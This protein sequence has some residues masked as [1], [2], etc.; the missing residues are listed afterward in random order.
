MEEPLRPRVGLDERN[1]ALPPGGEPQVPKRLVV[2]REEVARC[3]A[4]GRHV[5]N[6]GAVGHGERCE[7]MPEELDELADHS[8]TTEDLR[9]RQDEVGGRSALR[10]R[11]GQPKTDDLGDEHRDR[12]TQHRC[13]GFDPADTP[14]EHSKPVHHRRMRVGADERVGKCLTVA[15]LDDAGEV[16]EVDLMAD[17]GVRRHDTEVVERVLAPAKKRV[18]LPISLELELCIPCERDPARELVDLYRMVDDELGGEQRVDALR[19]S[20]QS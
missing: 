17:A 2:D 16:L 6:R 19:V 8:D 13:L 20:S 10:E 12:L 7:S 14:A 1:V 4:F 15:G 3:A 9:D 18:A 11:T 5:G